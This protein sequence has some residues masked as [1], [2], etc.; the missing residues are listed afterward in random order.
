[1]TRRYPPV[2]LSDGDVARVAEAETVAEC[3]LAET[4]LEPILVAPAGNSLENR[5]APAQ[6][7]D[8]NRPSAD[9]TSVQS[10]AEFRGHVGI[11]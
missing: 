8:R 9:W 10:V 3:P 11:G 2:T 5:S 6:R 4:A 7:C 1:M